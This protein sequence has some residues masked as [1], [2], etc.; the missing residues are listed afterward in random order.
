VD[1]LSRSESAGHR[2][3]RTLAPGVVPGG[4]GYPAAPCGREEWDLPRA[5][6]VPS[7]LFFSLWGFEAPL[8]MALETAEQGGFDGLELNIHH[9]SLA[10]DPAGEAGVTM[11][12]GLVRGPQEGQG[13]PAALRLVSRRRSRKR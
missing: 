6:P 13:R 8:A 9:P 1:P 4:D 11:A 7:L 3:S 12:T 10:G 2:S 5:S